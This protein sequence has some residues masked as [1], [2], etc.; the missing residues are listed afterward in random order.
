MIMR[1]HELAVKS[2]KGELNDAYFIAF[3]VGLE[4]DIEDSLK[5]LKTEVRK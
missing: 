1:L 4:A 5:K 3:Q 2:E